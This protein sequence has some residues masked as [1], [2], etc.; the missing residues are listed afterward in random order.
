MPSTP[1]PGRPVP[2]R[3]VA[4]LLLGTLLNP[5]NSSMIAV[6]LVQI[7]REFAVGIVA[8]SWLIS[9]F[10]L[11][12]AVGQPVFGRLAD[13]F[14]PRRVYCLGLVLVGVA[15]VLGPL[16]PTFGWLL[17]ARVLLACGDELKEVTTWP[18]RIAGSTR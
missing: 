15:G 3:V 7:E 14:G 10:Y 18:R 17:A 2:R 12:S 13:R 4:A 16:A 11:A 1:L 5:L 9:A 8:A 6:A